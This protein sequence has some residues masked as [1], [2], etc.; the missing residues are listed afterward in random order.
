MRTYMCLFILQALSE[1]LGDSRGQVRHNPCPQLSRKKAEFRQLFLTSVVNALMKN[2]RLG[3][4]RRQP[5]QLIGATRIQPR[6][7]RK[8]SL[9]AQGLGSRVT[10][11]A[12]PSCG[13][14]VPSITS[15]AWLDRG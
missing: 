1:A 3:I 15:S 5:L 11:V 8:T 7:P 6:H 14:S 10:G 12:A 4:P 2:R 9:L 13:E